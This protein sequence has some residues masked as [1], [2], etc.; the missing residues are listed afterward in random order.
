[1]NT[2]IIRLDGVRRIVTVQENEGAAL[3]H[4]EKILKAG[5]Q[6]YTTLKTELLSPGEAILINTRRN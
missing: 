3:Q 4:A 1:M 5:R 6:Q 2:Y